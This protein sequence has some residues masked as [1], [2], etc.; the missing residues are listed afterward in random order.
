M[1]ATNL[2]A[3]IAGTIYPVLN[4]TYG[5]DDKVDE[6]STVRLTIFDANNTYQFL[7]GEPV[8]IS[9][10]LEGIKFTGFVAKPVSTKYKANA[11]LAWQLDC[12]DNQFLAGKKTTNRIINN[13]YAGVAAAS[14]I[15]DHLSQD[16]VVANYA[17]RDDNTQSDFA[18]GTLSGT[19]AT[20]NLGGDLELAP[21]G[22]T[23]TITEATTSVFGNGTLTNMSA[24]N[25]ALGPS[26]TSAM[27][28]QATQSVQGI[29][30]SYTYVK[31]WA[32]TPINI[33]SGRYLTYDIWISS[34][35]PEAKIGI[36]L[37]FS[38]GTTL[39][40]NAIS[41]NGSYFDAQNKSPHPN[42]DLKGL[43]VDQWYH[44]SFL[45]DNF[46]GKTIS[47]AM[48]AIEGDSAGTYTG[49]V[50]NVVWLDSG[51]GNH[52]T[53]FSGSLNVSPP[54][55]MQ[56][57]GYGT[58]S[59][60]VVNTYDCSTASRVSPSYSI[61]AAKI[62]KSSFLTYKTG[63]NNPSPYNAI[64]PTGYTFNLQYSI[65]GGNSYTPL[66][67]NN[68][69]LPAL[70]AGQSISGKSI[71]FLQSFSQ[72]AGADPTQ[73]PT[74]TFMQA[75]L[76][77]SY[78]A[79]KSDVNT[80]WTTNSQWNNGTHTNTQATNNTLQPF[81]AVQNYDAGNQLSTV[82]Q[83]LYGGGATGPNNANSCFQYVDSKQFR[84]VVH[85]STEA[86][87]RCDFAGQWAD[88]QMEFDVSVDNNNMKVGCVYRT[89]GWSNY[90]GTFAYG[91]EIIGTTI[92]LFKG[93]N[94]GGA[95]SNASVT[96]VGSTATVNLTSQAM[97]RIK[98]I[99]S[100]SS[101]QIYFDDTLAINATD[102]TY[103]G[104]GNVG[105]RISN[106]D[107]SNGYIG[108]F[109]NFGISPTNIFSGANW[110][111]QSVSLAGAGTYLN[112]VVQWDD[113]TSDPTQTA[114]NLWV[115]YNGGSTWNLCTNGAALPGLTAGQSLSGV[116]ALFQMLFSYNTSTVL[117]QIQDLTLY[118]LGGF[119]SSGTRIAPMLS[120]ANAGTA[121]S[122]VT[123]WTATTP[124][125]TSVTVATS[126]DGVTY[127]NVSNGGSIAGITAQPSPTLD[128]FDSNSSPNYTQSNRTGGSAGTWF[129][130]T[131]NSRLSVSGGTN[132]ILLLSSIPTCKDVDMILDF[133]QADQVG[134]VW[135][136]TD[137][138][139]FYEIDVFDASSSTGTTNK[140]RL[141][142][143]VANV[144]TQIGS[145][146]PIVLTR[147]YKYRLH[148][149][150]VGTA[151]NVW[152]DGVNLISTTDSS[153]TAA[154]L[155]GIIATGVGRFY[156]FRVQ[157]QGDNLSNKVVYSKVTLTS[158][159]PTVTPQLTDLTVAALH[160]NIG[161]GALIPTADY[162]NTYLSDNLNDLAK[163][164][165]YTQ[166]ID[167]NLNFI[168]N[169]RTALPAPWILQSA[170]QQLLLDGPLTVDYS[171][172]LYRN[173][174]V[175]NGVVATGTKSET[176]IGD[177]TSTSWALGG[178]IVS[179]PTIYVN[180][181]LK[182]IGIK[183]ID[184]GKDFY[185]TPGSNAIDQDSSGTVL[186]QTDT[187][188]FQN[189]TYQYITS[190]TVDNTNLSNT[191][192]QKQFAARMGRTT[193]Q[194]NVLNQ[195]SAA[196]TTSSDFG[197]LDVSKCR[198][199]A[200]DINITAVSGTS[201]TIQFFVDR[202]DV[203][204]IYYQLWSS[205]V[206]SAASPISTTIGAFAAINQALGTTVR[207]R[208]TITGTTPSFTFSASITG[209]L[210]VQSAGLGIVAV[211]E[212]V[213]SQ[214]LNVAAATAYANGLLQ[215]Y[216][217]Q[218][219]TITFK[220]WRRNP[221]LAIGQYLPVFIPEHNIND[222]SML[223]TG[224]ST[225]QSIG[226]ENGNP[227]QI[228]WQDIICTE[229]ANIGSAWRLLATTLK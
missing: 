180:G 130:D 141:Y 213:S 57:Q 53:F 32:G 68:A 177:G 62:L 135:R 172:D 117:P 82:V 64:L 56:K 137:A 101:H 158:T 206:V 228:Y 2:T 187:L 5:L 150:M 31:F 200:V 149:S 94:N 124:T 132:A 7:F 151:I 219:R 192:T 123:N 29:S 122:T 67:S 214:S 143:V 81:G 15:N 18:A 3:S 90:D 160:P 159:D 108:T 35:S 164:S 28:I 21:A 125:N 147:G 134:L 47:Y 146:V 24:S 84:L 91:I 154:G 185:Y 37:V 189:Y 169:A 49:Y 79:T 54:Q 92:K 114:N 165:D 175:L 38:D 19:A 17:I 181:Q 50:K 77:P 129:W 104:A 71:Q 209:T 41:N 197:D 145:D 103:T 211:V 83:T 215:K 26:A 111:S 25:N 202:K 183:G 222:A 23:T 115:S 223:I 85:Q 118:V 221:S 14:M 142:K 74:L 161:L 178:E 63:S 188:L 140:I 75:M 72:G 10:T 193:A 48:I 201:P 174:M 86:R 128:T 162:T 66:T 121:G 152:I 153:I 199:I 126:L 95:S 78:S 70:L 80:E 217:T 127:T 30:N 224:I 105:F 166:F 205:N 203:N 55:Q 226:T 198:R 9:D 196:H 73:Q 184:T 229:L 44:R 102:S 42:T 106:T 100:G 98:L 46:S 39:R 171:A 218:G 204:G 52:G 194:Q 119:S 110:T 99:I 65:D 144:K 1:T 190:I 89:T 136:E 58:T 6:R 138:S 139:N 11:A 13:Q 170:D 195:A 112:S 179:P 167:Q 43:A 208:W 120:L 116:S 87:S 60:T 216:G 4:T 61:D 107:A 34:S 212:D 88:F 109:D 227:T 155:V 113:I 40:D 27:K 8:V 168:F 225:S 191:V 131:L 69:S 182:T 16:G 148:L 97:H 210:D 96:Q 156:N 76:Y 33:I 173:E 51:G 12:M 207:L 186:Q 22:S 176:K 20:S 163:K 59:V 220:T 93:S 157:P 45:M 133:D 36:D